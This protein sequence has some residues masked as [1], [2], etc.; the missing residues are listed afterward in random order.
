MT[1]I[2][3]FIGAAAVSALGVAA[4]VVLAVPAQAVTTPDTA[5][6][7]AG[8][9]NEDGSATV[10]GT[11]TCPLGYTVY[12]HAN[13]YQRPR[14]GQG[15]WHHF[16]TAVSCTGEPQPWSATTGPAGFGPGAARVYAFMCT[17]A[18]PDQGCSL[19]RGSVVLDRSVGAGPR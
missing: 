17:A 15:I 18:Q 14:F 8:A 10:S 7:M 5:I 11:V 2:R 19:T 4:P 12:G 3:T 13:V 9:A 6:T 16:T 1:S